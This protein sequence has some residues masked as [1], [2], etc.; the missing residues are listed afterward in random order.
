[1]ATEV[2]LVTCDAYIAQQAAP[3]DWYLANILRDDALLA[4]AFESQGIGTRR[5]S[6]TDRSV[7]WN[8][9]RCAILRTTWDYHNRV[10]EFSQW[11]HFV[12]SQTALCNPFQM[13]QWNIDKHYLHA[14]A[15]KGSPVVPTKYLEPGTVCDLARHFDELAVSEAVIK[16]CISAGAR[17]T[18]RFSR[19]RCKEIESIIEPLLA[20]EAFMLQPFVPQVLQTG[21][22][23][24]M[25]A[26][27]RFTHA[28][29]KRPKAGDF[30]VQD[31]YGG[32]FVAHTPTDL[33]IQVAE[34]AMAR[35]PWL[36]M[37]GR[38]DMVES[39]DGTPW[40][41]EV[42]LIEPELW[43][44]SHPDSASLFAQAIIDGMQLR[45]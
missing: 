2:A 18:Y 25:V 4:Q 14:L 16:P 29:R 22:D 11:L 33:Q 43:I 44:R 31:D 28:V 19:E 3:D 15:E 5:V 12:N 41:M 17:H 38:V 24:L 30:R 37:Y 27:G 45:N 7:R 34:E 21:E 39:S 8:D 26:G 9:F 40:I 32:T 23:T 20:R 10:E 13:I 36:P 42:E 6:W 35:V 1:M